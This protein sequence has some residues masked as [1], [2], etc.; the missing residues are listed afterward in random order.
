MDIY[1]LCNG[2][3]FYPVLLSFCLQ[4]T[5]RK[6]INLQIDVDKPV[7]KVSINL[8]CHT[9]VII[10]IINAPAFAYARTS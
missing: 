9:A 8:L 6:V 2:V 5:Y 1:P 7:G 3:S 10:I 4:I